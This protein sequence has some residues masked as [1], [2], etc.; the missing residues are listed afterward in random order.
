WLILI[1]AAPAL[2]DTPWWESFGDEVL[3]TLVQ[4]GLKNNPDIEIA[5]ARVVQSEA[6]FS[7][8][9]ASLMPQLSF[10]VGVNS[11]PYADAY[12]T[13]PTLPTTPVTTDNPELLHSGSAMLVL[14]WSP[15]IWGQRILN[16]GASGLD[17][18]ASELELEYR[19]SNLSATIVS[20][21]FDL[22]SATSQL[23]LLQEQLKSQRSFL[24]IVERR[25]DTAAATILEVLQQKQQVAAREAQLPPIQKQ[26]E[27]TRQQL[28]I[29]V[30]RTPDAQLLLQATSLPELPEQMP[31]EEFLESRPDL[32][33]SKTRVEAAE[34]RESSA[35]RNFLP[36]LG[37]SAQAGFTGK[38]ANEFDDDSTWSTAVSLSVPLFSGGANF[39]KL[40]QAEAGTTIAR[41]SH[42]SLSL[43][44]KRQLA[45]ARS[46]EE[47]EK[48]RLVAIQAQAEA[49]TM[50]FK[51]GQ[52]RYVAGL[53]SYLNV[54]T[55]LSTHQQAELSLIIA[56]RSLLQSRIQH[57]TA[58]G[59]EWMQ[60][61]SNTTTDSTQTIFTTPGETS[62]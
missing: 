7:Q 23:T 59:G 46:T 42:L 60:D 44:V 5:R 19:A 38:Y 10:D 56:K 8:S 16:T 43:E 27:L 48:L 20:S 33:A 49:A 35:Y 50:A 40:R 61:L 14:R 11:Q 13:T 41:S 3:N 57:H 54:L 25:F 28:A 37:L 34:K 58:A 21:Y 9:R 31:S 30:G 24:E 17:M 36:T 32:K 52:S 53:D 22:L 55:A 62:Q 26:I 6:I 4:E 15:D 12:P 2:A 45:A 1:S 39:A 47:L 18:E 29:L 51:E